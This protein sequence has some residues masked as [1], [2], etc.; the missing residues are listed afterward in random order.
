[1][2]ELVWKKFKYGYRSGKFK[3]KY[4][5]AGIADGWELYMDNVYIKL[6][7]TE[8]EAKDLAQELNDK[9]K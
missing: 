7:D 4:W 1:M 3:I 2:N 9:E 8:K 6:C 5:E